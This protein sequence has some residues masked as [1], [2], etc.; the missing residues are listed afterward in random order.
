MRLVHRP[1]SAGALAG[2][3]PSIEGTNVGKS[4]LR[5]TDRLSENLSSKLK[6][7]HNPSLFLSSHQ[8]SGE[9]EYSWNHLWTP[10]GK[11]SN[12]LCTS[13]ERDGT[14]QSRAKRNEIA[15]RRRN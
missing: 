5:Q 7:S 12:S 4:L 1:S 11:H 6:C 14:N 13:A 10:G 2:P 8:V 3:I 9:R 15:S